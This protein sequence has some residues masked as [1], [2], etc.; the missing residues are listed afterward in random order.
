MTDPRT[1]AAGLTGAQKHILRHS[2]GVPDPGQ[3]NMYRNHFVTGEG[4]TDYPDCM[5]LLGLGMMTR[6]N[7]NELTGG[8]DAFF[9]TEIGKAAV[10][11]IL[12]E[13]NHAK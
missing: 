7:G 5:A 8:D 3:T 1:I 4:S 12:Q 6:Q 2:L 13:Q 11:K 10:R 9:V